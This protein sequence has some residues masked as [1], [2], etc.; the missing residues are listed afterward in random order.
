MRFAK[1]AAGAGVLV[2]V[3]IIGGTLIG[4]VLAAPRSGG[5]NGSPSANGG[6]WLGDA[7]EYCDVY[8]D[9]LAGELG[10]SRDDLLPAGQA[11][12]KAA[13]DAAVAA[14]D[15]D[16]DRAAELKERIDAIEDAGCGGLLG[17]IGHPFIRGFAHG[18]VHADVIDAAADALGLDRSELFERFADGDSLEDIA[19][20]QKVAYDEVKADVLAALD[21]DLDAAVANGLDQERADAVHDRAAAWLDNGGEPRLGPSHF[22]EPSTDGPFRFN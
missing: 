21:A 22:G 8:L 16:A 11:A 10:V 12:A 2:A 5:T 20:D 9:T 18:V 15:L 6:P 19:A 13:I 17:G 7:G 4:S 1:L 14:G 3:S